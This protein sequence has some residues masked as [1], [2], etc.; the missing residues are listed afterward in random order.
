MDNHQVNDKEVDD[1]QE[2]A[3]R[4][5]TPNRAS[6]HPGSTIQGGS[7]FGQGSSQLGKK[8]IHQGEKKNDGSDYKNESEWNNEA[9]RTEDLDQTT[10][11]DDPKK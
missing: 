1:N 10:K 6:E 4:E 2:K 5:G 9:L 3:V 7:D 11:R 8:A